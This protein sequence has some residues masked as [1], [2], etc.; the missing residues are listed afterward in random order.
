MARTLGDRLSKQWGQPI[1]VENRAG[2]SGVPAMQA[3]RSA[4]SDGY[5][6]LMGASGP[7]AG[8]PALFDKLPYDPLQDYVKAE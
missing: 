6:L 8:N 5:T 1:V 2:G 3:G 7:M 4:A